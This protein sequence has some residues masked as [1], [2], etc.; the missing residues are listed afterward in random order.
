MALGRDWELRIE[1]WCQAVR[2]R[3]ATPVRELP[4]EFAATMDQLAPEKARRLRFRPIRPGQRWGRKWEYG[5]FRCTAR[6][7][8]VAAGNRVVLTARPGERTES[9]VFIDG[10]A[11]G[12]LDRWHD[13][14][15]LTAIARPG[16][17][18]KVLIESYAGHGPTPVHCSFL[19]PGAEPAPPTPPRQQSFGGA[20]LCEWNEPAYQLWIDAETVRRL[21]PALP[22]DS[23]RR[24]R[25]EEAI[26]DVTTALDPEAPREEFD[27]AIPAARKLLAPVLSARNGATAPEMYCFGHAHIDVAWL[28]P[29]AQTFRKSAHTFATALALMDRYKEFRFLQSQAQ[30]YE[31]L[32]AQYPGIYAGIKRAVRRGQWMPEGAMWVEADTNVSGGEALIRQFLYGRRFFKQ[33]FGVESQVCWLPDVFGYSANLPQILR[34]C[35]MKYFTTQK[36]FWNYYGGTTFPYETFMWQ[37]IDGTEILTHLHRNYN[38]ETHPQAVAGRWRDCVDKA[39]TH[40]FLYPFGWGDGGGG[41]TRDHLEHLR[42]QRDLEGL[43]RTR[44]AWPGEFFAELAKTPP[45]ARYAGELYLEVH[46]GTYTS[47]ART[48]RGNR[49]CEL[50]LREAEMWSAAAAAVHG[51]PYPA[52]ELERAWKK[53]LLNQ[54][55]DILPG[56]S[57][58]RVYQ[59]AE[60]LYAEVLVDCERLSAAARRSLAPGRAGWTVWNS[61][62]WPRDVLVSLPAA[63]PDAHRGPVDSDG[64]PLPAQVVGRGSSRRLL[65]AVPAV[66]PV[67]CKTIRLASGRPADCPSPATARAARGGAVMENEHLRLRINSRGEIAELYDKSAARQLVPP[68]QTMNR[69]ELYRDNPGSWDAWDIDIAYKQSPVRLGPAEAVDVVAA[70]PLEGRVAV[71]R[72]L[73][74][75]KLSQEIVLRAGSRRIDFETRV[76][77]RQP[78]RLLKVAF[79]AD[80]SAAT[81]RGEI[82]FG[83]VVRPRH[84]NTEFE[85]QRFEW[86]AQK[87]ADLSEAGYGMA[88]LNDCKYGYDFLDGVL[89][90]TLLRAPVLPDPGADRGRHE[91]TYSL[92]PHHGP[93]ADGQVVRAAYE[94]NVPALVLPGRREGGRWS[95]LEVSNPAIVV[96]TVKRSEDG[97]GTVVRLYE[98]VGAAAE[99]RVR[100]AAGA[101]APAECD[102][103]ENPRRGLRPA[104]DGTVRL[105]FRPF[106]VKTVRL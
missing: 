57:I 53:V 25:L 23:L 6:V 5:W 15:D 60:K 63:N 42:R 18:L 104:G 56:S 47:Q 69:L 44:Y 20:A 24:L 81:L 26:R 50:A 48:K 85:R 40:K 106:E 43:P 10:E 73:G 41:P 3:V 17:R 95:F 77:W 97:R 89:R 83:H 76:D 64:T 39:G 7:P 72:P 91:F 37:G 93:F 59:Q 88:V 102:M 79:P 100:V 22:A 12:G 67:G 8:P 11:A 46:R 2:Q 29:L 84:R 90:L 33:E 78:H 66:P 16:Q 58:A 54:F 4:A 99:A 82:Q 13:H 49:K 70:G 101:E 105:R 34:G 71:R 80:L 21:I 36:L 61:L 96:E 30:L 9:I 52:R 68:G 86:P 27:A 28:W 92:L 35:G 55:H 38:A 65:V 103:L 62:S 87:W 31:F 75:S 1:N 51:R 32:K 14:V 74:R 19:L 45:Q 98:S 94:L